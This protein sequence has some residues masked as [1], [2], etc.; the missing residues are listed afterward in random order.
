[1][2]HKLLRIESLF[3]FNARDWGPD[4]VF[5]SLHHGVF[6]GSFLEKEG[7]MFQENTPL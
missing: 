7:P 5:R 3:V 1:L 4:G 6:F 2:K